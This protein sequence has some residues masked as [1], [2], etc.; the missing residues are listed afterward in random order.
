MLYPLSQ[1]YANKHIIITLLGILTSHLFKI[2]K[3]VPAY[4][5]CLLSPPASLK[6]QAIVSLKAKLDFAGEVA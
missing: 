1:A 5:N 2:I 6:R 3:A 4:R